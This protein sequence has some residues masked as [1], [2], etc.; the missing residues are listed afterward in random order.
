MATQHSKIDLTPPWEDDDNAA[1]ATSHSISLASQP[2]PDN[3]GEATHAATLAT[4]FSSPSPSTST[5]QSQAPTSEPGFAA[6]EDAELS[7]DSLIISRPKNPLIDR[8]LPGLIYGSFLG[9]LAFMFTEGLQVPTWQKIVA[10]FG[11]GPATGLDTFVTVPAS[12]PKTARPELPEPEL[13]VNPYYFLPTRSAA[14][15]QP[16]AAGDSGALY[17][18]LKRYEQSG[19]LGRYQ[20]LR[21]LRQK[22]EKAMVPIFTKA[23]GEKKLWLVMEAVFG[24]IACGEPVSVFRLERKLESVRPAL[25][26]RYIKRLSNPPTA[27]ERVWLRTMIKADLPWLR[28]ML[29]RRLGASPLDRLYRAAAHYDKNAAVR[30]YSRSL[31]KDARGVAAYKKVWYLDLEQMSER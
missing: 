30:R 11:E 22:P 26:A 13:M 29:L 7:A 25:M 10:V 23:L 17:A 31:G 28:P 4:P 24:L 5:N 27:T 6:V 16:V 19:G 15:R 9:L 2:M 12:D 21:A 3:Q 18:T 20:L 14:D 8:V 1:V